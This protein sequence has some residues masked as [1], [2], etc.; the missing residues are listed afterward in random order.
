MVLGSLGAFLV[1]EARG[2]AEARNAKPLA[3]LSR[4]L[5]ER[6]SRPAG[7]VSAALSR[8]WQSLAPRPSGAGM[9]V[10]SGA[11]GAQPATND[12][13]AW[14]NTLADVPVRATG[15]LLGH[16]FEPQFSMNIALATLALARE[17]LFPPADASGFE[18]EYEGP[19]ERVAVTAVGHWRGE[20]MA[21]VEAVR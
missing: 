14:L 16:G 21:L 19:L 20:G 1:L 6:S 5:S 3:R 2:H 4:V 18:R 10:I 13:R 17:K 7:G 15:T 11:T 9:A 12:E 8:M